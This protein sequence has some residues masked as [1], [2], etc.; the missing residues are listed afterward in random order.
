[1]KLGFIGTGKIASSVILGVCK[2]KIKFRQIILSPRNKRIA[3]NL[4]KKF[5]KISIAKDNQDVIN[6][7]NWIFLSVTPVVGEKII[8]K[9]K[10]K[11]SQTIISFI[12]TIGLL[13]LKRMIKVKSKVVRAI[14]LPPISI[15][16]GP[17]PIYPPNKKVKFFFDKIGSTIE[18]KNEKLS[19]NFWSTSG[20]MASYYEILQIMSNWLIKKGV[21]RQDAQKYITSLFL[22]LSE[23]AVVNSKKDLRHLVRES[24]TPNGLNEQGLKEM[25]KRGIYKSIVNSLNSIYKRINKK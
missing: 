17:V 3:N 16:K 20:M 18:I 23:D 8:K 5:K 2:S 19:I 4:K 7:S 15:K 25:K 10:F 21:K 14:P 12:S 9:L 6:K 22:A 1:M 24:Q 11:S 13:D